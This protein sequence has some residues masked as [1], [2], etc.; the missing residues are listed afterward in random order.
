MRA[1]EELQKA[2]VLRPAPGRTGIYSERERWSDWVSPIYDCEKIYIPVFECNHWYVAIMDMEDCV[3]RVRVSLR[4][5][6][7]I[8]ILAVLDEILRGIDYAFIEELRE[9]M[10]VDWKFVSFVI[11]RD[12]CEVDQCEDF[13]CGIYVIKCMEAVYKKDRVCNHVCS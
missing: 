7:L 4:E 13:S 3:V 1:E 8:I 12:D 10:R 11:I 9:G 6:P 2:K 5:I